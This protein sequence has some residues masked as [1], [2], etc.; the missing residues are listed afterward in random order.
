MSKE[1][2]IVLITG[3]FLNF[4]E[5]TYPLLVFY[6]KLYITAQKQ[7]IRFCFLHQIVFSRVKILNNIPVSKIPVSCII[8]GIN[9][10][11]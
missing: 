6:E 9:M 1:G 11:R 7:S 3:N 4:F 2:E 10:N 5:T 8:N